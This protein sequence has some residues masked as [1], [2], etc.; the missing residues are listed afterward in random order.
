MIVKVE[1]KGFYLVKQRLSFDFHPKFHK[2]RVEG[3]GFYL[4][5]QRLSFDFHPKFHKPRVVNYV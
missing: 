4:V 3:K 2:P 5:K 1:G